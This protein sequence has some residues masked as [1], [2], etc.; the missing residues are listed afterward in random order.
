MNTRQLRR[1]H[2]GEL[3]H[4]AVKVVRPHTG[5]SGRY[6]AI[7]VD[8]GEGGRVGRDGLGR[9]R[10]VGVQEYPRGVPLICYGEA[11]HSRTRQGGDRTVLTL[12]YVDSEKVSAIAVCAGHVCEVAVQGD[13]GIAP[14]RQGSKVEVHH[15][16]F[17]VGELQLRRG[18]SALGDRNGCG[19]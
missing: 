9:G 17:A 7:A 18:N 4:V 3:I 15:V 11:Q 1:T 10:K 8:D 19:W 12:P 2:S 5:D 13:G 14:R 6:R 16:A